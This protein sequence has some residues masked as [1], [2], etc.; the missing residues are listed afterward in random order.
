MALK[1]FNDLKKISLKFCDSCEIITLSISDFDKTYSNTHGIVNYNN[2]GTPES[3]SYDR[4]SV[5]LA[6]SVKELSEKIDTL[7]NRLDAIGA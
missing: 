5:F 6:L 7:S 2:E 1:K 3:I 4:L